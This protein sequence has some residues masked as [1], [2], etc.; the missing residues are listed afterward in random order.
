MKAS[1]VYSQFKAKQQS[2]TSLRVNSRA[3]VERRIEAHR[4][5][6]AASAELLSEPTNESLRRAE[7]LA[8]RVKK[9]KTAAFLSKYKL[10]A[11][12]S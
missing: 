3:E 4:S 10:S 8:V 2:K 1:A 12:A 9:A 7:E 6:R 5:A 11:V